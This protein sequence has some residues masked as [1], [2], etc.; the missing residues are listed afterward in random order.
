MLADYIWSVVRDRSLMEFITKNLTY[1]Y[2]KFTY[3]Y[4]YDRLFKCI[5][6]SQINNIHIRFYLLTPVNK[7]A[8]LHIY[9]YIR[10]ALKK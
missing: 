7:L 9:T 4:N 5:R 3:Y 10:A 8:Q 6:N 1:T 2:L